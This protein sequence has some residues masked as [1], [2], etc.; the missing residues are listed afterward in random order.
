[1]LSGIL[2]DL[3]FAL[4]L[5]AK[6]PGFT[7]VAVG[8]LAL[9]IAVNT[10]LFT[11]VNALLLRPLPYGRPDD[12]VEI[13]LPR[14]TIPMDELRQ[15]RSFES[16]GAY[17]PANFPVAGDEGT[18]LVFGCRVSAGMFSLLDVQPALGRVFTANEE[19]QPV[20][21]LSHEYWQRLSGDPNI[22]GK[23][24]RMGEQDRTVVGV[25]PADFTLF[26]RDGHLW[27]P[28]RLTQGRL[29]AR[30]RP[31]VSRDQADAETAAILAGLPPEPGPSGQPS[32]GPRSR[33][34][35]LAIAFLPNDAPTVLILQAAV[36]MVLLITCANV[37]NL[38]LVRAAG[39]RR[40]FAIRTAI[41]AGRW[42]VARQLMA[43]SVLLAA[44]GGA[45]GLL[46]AHWSV[47]FLRVELPVN[48][49]RIL[50]GAEGLSIDARV[51]AFTA[52]ATLLT[53]LL[54]GMAPVLGALR[55][56]V[57]RCLRDS[58]RGTVGGRQRLGS[59]L[60]AAEIALA[61]MLVTGAGLLLKSLDGLEKQDLGFR[62]DRV[63]R[64]YFELPGTRYPL[65]EHRLTVFADILRQVQ[66]L[67]GV[68]S[69]G[70]LAPQFFPFG[71]PRVTGAPLEIESQAG[72]EAR[73]E[74]Y[75][76]SPD[77]FRVVRIPL[78][79]GRLF[80][81]TDTPTST[82]VAVI[83]DVVA[84]RYWPQGDPIGRRIRPQPAVAGNP[85]VT[86]VGVVGDT[87]N[88]I[89]RG[90]QPTVY[91]PWTQN[92]YQGG[93]VLIRASGD[94]AALTPEV[95]RVLRGFDPGAPEFRIA[96]LET[97]VHDYIRPQRFNTSLFGFFAAM[98]L[99]LAGLGVYGVK[100]HRVSTRI[101]EI[102]VRLALGASRGAVL[103]M[104]LGW[105]ART[106]AIGAVAGLAG[107]LA[108][109]R[110]IA[111]ELY[112]VS[113]TD[114]IVFSAVALLI[115]VIALAAAFL[116]ARWAAKVDPLVALRHE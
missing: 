67:P 65:A 7:A 90:P 64:A 11:V 1:M 8:S 102:G 24:I 72:V 19:D 77:Y 49:A 58:A 81:D 89:G 46:L 79:R 98:G 39:R 25:L 114:P 100:R 70:L 74:T 21:L 50:R 99:F 43:E 108:L 76:A 59:L 37:A 73:G 97:A 78:I 54:F 34:T 87:R 35:P 30:L 16:V 2:R 5:L 80:A 68:E 93:V 31:G 41:G 47:S 66:A 104:V 56:D 52:G 4:R 27:I 83:A 55:F 63:L 14:R 60:A 57:M 113:P 75:V 29:L 33:V 110:V 20:V 88:P 91:R 105:A 53:A 6:S 32:R 23:T 17:S 44:F 62:S 26:F 103:G 10:S 61:L 18:K 51:I 85:W 95:R 96:N 116:P 3:R 86:I 84:K 109:Q 22:I 82:P 42:Q 12:L 111:S 40:E 106:A 101:P 28:Q 107:A 115:A 94:P 71:G 36:G 9:G 13:S 38:L 15:A 92:P 69:A 45:A 48:L 112:G